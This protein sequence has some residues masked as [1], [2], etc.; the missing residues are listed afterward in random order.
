MRFRAWHTS[1]AAADLD[2]LFY[3][4]VERE[5]Q[6]DAGDLTLAERALAAIRS[7]FATVK[8]SPFTC[9]Q[10]AQSPFLPELI[11]PFGDAG[12]V[13]LF[14][15][16]GPGDVVIIAVRHQL[17]DDYHRSGPRSQA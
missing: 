10:A 6:R 11:I 12:V 2:R 3:F 16:E 15:I 8:A 1:E 17:E 7:G 9:R 14:E 5:L 4:I 13:A